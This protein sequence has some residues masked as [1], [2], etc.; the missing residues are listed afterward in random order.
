LKKDDLLFSIAGS[1]GRI[2]IIND[3]VLP[4][5]TNQALA[6][7]RFNENHDFNLNFIESRLNTYDI[8]KYIFQNLAV[9]AQPNLNLQQVGNISIN[10]P[11]YLEQNKIQNFIDKVNR[12]I[13]LFEEKHASYVNFKKYLMQ[14]I[15]TQKLRFD[16]FDEEWK[17]VKLKDIVERVTRRNSDLQ[18]NL[19]LTI[20]AEYGLIDQ[21]KFFNK[22]VASKSLKNY[23]LIKNGEFAYNKSYSSG[24]PFGA[25]K[26][27]NDYDRGALSTLYICFKPTNVD[28]DFLQEYFET[29][30]W[31]KEIYKIAVEGARNHGL[32]N[33][34]VGDFFNTKH[35]IPQSIEEQQEIADFLKTINLKILQSHDNLNKFKNF[36]KG[37]L[38][39]MFV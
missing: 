16:D 1:L 21:E 13:E 30:M 20:S 36:K 5:N 37:L 31:Y 9:G 25:I 24:Y 35:I 22:I 26:R 12:K 6:I 19:A 4:A 2:T 10:V 32:L 34:A 18:S 39:Q 7:I 33:I 28:S 14:Q 17:I 29:T 38:Q 23:Y 15:F 11:S 27:L 8:A 3:D